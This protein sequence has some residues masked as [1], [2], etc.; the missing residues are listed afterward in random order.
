M[1]TP[2]PDAKMVFVYRP[3]QIISA[4]NYGAELGALEGAKIA[5]IPTAG[6]A[7][8]NFEMTGC[9]SDV[10][11][12][13]MDL[14]ETFNLHALKS[15]TV[16]TAHNTANLDL[17]D[18]VIM[19][20]NR[21]RH[22]EKFETDCEKLIQKIIQTD[23][24]LNRFLSQVTNPTHYGSFNEL[25]DNTDSKP[26]SKRVLVIWDVPLTIGT[27]EESANTLSCIEEARRSIEKHRPQKIVVLGT[28]EKQCKGIQQAVSRFIYMVFNGKENEEEEQ[29]ELERAE[30]LRRKLEAKAYLKTDRLNLPV[31]SD[32]DDDKDWDM[33]PDKK[34]QDEEDKR[35]GKDR[36]AELAAAHK[37]IDAAIDGAFEEGVS[38]LTTYE[39]DVSNPVAVQSSGAIHTPSPS[40]PHNVFVAPGASAAIGRGAM[41]IKNGFDFTT[42]LGQEVL[43][44]MGTAP[45]PSLSR[46]NVNFSSGSVYV[47]AG[48]RAAIG[49]GAMLLE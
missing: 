7:P 36:D 25:F 19:F 35:K 11:T 6:F 38:K 48:A 5:G 43:N 24:N 14:A 27:P 15:E 8:A 12:Q 13:R 26:D 3:V 42:P 47:S 20:R 37:E 21:K 40:P 32:N 29:L 44:Q 10:P 41:L 18:F 23:R 30:G 28:T 45:T 22:N 9:S 49:D 17:A 34:T 2:E 46:A 1:S 39:Q 33:V 31:T 16:A 4:G